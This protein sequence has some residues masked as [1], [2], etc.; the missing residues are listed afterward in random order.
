[1]KQQKK[2]TIPDTSAPILRFSLIL[3]PLI[4]LSVDSMKEVVN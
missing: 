2:T 4:G 1:M 3:I